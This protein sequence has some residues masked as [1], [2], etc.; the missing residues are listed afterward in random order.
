MCLHIPVQLVEVDVGQQGAD[1]AS[2]WRPRRGVFE[3][4]SFHHPSLKEALQESQDFLILDPMPKKLEELL[5]A[6]RVEVGGNVSFDHPE[7]LRFLI[8]YPGDVAEGT[9]GTAVRTESKGIAAEVGLIDGFQDHPQGF[10][11]NSVP[12]GRDAQIGC[13]TGR[14]NT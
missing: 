11:D 12:D 3:Q 6:D 10:L 5:V 4:L 14:R 2:L 13:K 1:D 7:E 9:D 8:G